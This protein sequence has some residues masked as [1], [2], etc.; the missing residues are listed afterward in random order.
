MRIVYPSIA[1]TDVA[2]AY[3]TPLGRRPDRPWVMLSMVASIDGSTVVGGRS[4]ALSNPTD[5]TVLSQ[6]RSI[7]DVVIVGAAT[8]AGEGYGPP[9]K[10]SQRIGVVTRSGSVD[11]TTDLFRS[12]A[13][14]VVTTEDA[15][16]DPTSAGDSSVDVLRCGQGDVDL[17]EMVR[18]IPEVCPG[19]SVIQAE[20]GPRLNGSFA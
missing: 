10:A 9:R 6:L 8:A 1:E 7:A 5:I 19:A 4:E 18:R 15:V 3:A 2:S 12:G 11:T 16:V 13:G 17:H 20:G 14:F